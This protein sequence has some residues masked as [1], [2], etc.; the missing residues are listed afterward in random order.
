[1]YRT[2]IFACAMLAGALSLTTDAAAQAGATI[3]GRLLDSLTGAPIAGA[4]VQLEELRRQ[5]T[6]GADGSF[7]FDNVPAGTY[8][9]SVRTSGYSSR[10]TE[11]VA[12][13]PAAMDI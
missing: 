1:M 13:T 11:I 6:S 2:T 5:S 4:T 10:R 8:H 7:T 3:S 9:V 12:P